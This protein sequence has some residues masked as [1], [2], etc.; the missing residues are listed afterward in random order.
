[1]DIFDFR[2]RLV[3][4]Y[5]NYVKS[6][7]RIQNERINAKVQDSFDRG[8]LWPDPLLQL[9]PFFA[10]GGQIDELI[11]QGQLAAEC[12]DIFRIKKDSKNPRGQALRLHKHQ[13]EAVEIA[14]QGHHYVLTTGTGS[15]KS[16]A[17]IVPIVNHILRQ[18]SGKGIQAIVVYPMN[19]L[20][21]SQQ[22][23]LEK[24][25]GTTDPAVTFNRYTGQDK[26]EA[27]RQILENPP[28]ILLTNYVMLEL[29]LTRPRENALIESAKGLQF[30]V[31]DELHTY[32]GRQGADVAMLVRRVRDRLSANN[33]Q[34]V[35]TSATMSTEGTYLDRQTAVAAVASQIFG[36]TVQP[37]HVIGE[38]LRRIT[39]EQTI[40]SADF[41]ERLTERVI[42][43]TAVPQD[44]ENFVQDPL[45]I[46]IES[47]FGIAKESGSDRYVRQKPISL[48]GNEGAAKK[49][50]E[51][52]KVDIPQCYQTL[53]IALLRGYSCA[54]PET[55]YAPFGFRLHQFISKGGAV[56]ASLEDTEER[57]ITLQAQQYVPG[58]R[59][60]ILLPLVFCRE[61]GQEYYCVRRTHTTEDIWELTARELSDSQSES[62]DEAGFI[63]A[64]ADN[65][66]SDDW[67]QLEE[68]LPDDWLEEHETKRRGRHTRVK[69]A[70]RKHLPEP[71]QFKA[72]GEL[73]SKQGPLQGRFLPA[74]FR[75]CLSCGVS[76]GSR[77][78]SDFA[79][80]STLGTEGR[81]TATTILGL[82]SILSLRESS[83]EENAKKLLSFTDNRQDAALQA[84]HFNDF[85]E[86]GLLRAAV[87]A[88]IKNQ[89]EGVE[90]DELAQQVF[91]ALNLPLSLYASDPDVQYQALKQTK[92]ALRDVLG[93]RLYLDLRRGW[94]I[95]SPNLEQ[96]GLLEIAYQS[97]EEACADEKIWQ[98][99]HLALSSATAQ[100]RTKVARVLLDY[101]RR[102]LAIKVNYLD[103]DYQERM[104]QRSSQ[105][106]IDPWSLDDNERLVHSAVLFPRPS[107]K[108]DF[109]GNVFLSPRGGFGYYIMRHST[110]QEVG[111]R[112][113]LTDAD[114][115]IKDLL[116]GLRK[117]G[118]VE[119]VM[120]PKDAEDVPGYQLVADTMLWTVG[121]GQ[122]AFHDPI[123]VPQQSKTGGNTNDFFVDFYKSTAAK[124]KN[125]EAREH[126]AQVPSEERER[127]EDAFRTA[128]LPLLFC[129]PTMEL[130]VDIDNLNVVSL[131]NIPPTPANYAQRSG[132][133]GRSGQPALVFSYCSTGSSHD[134]YFFKRPD[135]M[136]T[137]AVTP[138]R[139]DL[140]NE[141]L[142]RS[143]IH[144]IWLA[145]SG[146]FLGKSV[147]ELLDVTQEPPSLALGQ[148]VL[149]SLR[150]PSVRSRAQT[151]AENVLATIESV[152]AETDWHRAQWLEDVINQL[153]QSFERAC[154]RW[155]ELYRAALRQFELQSKII[156][157]VSRIARDKDQA[158]RLRR[159]A[160]NQLQILTQTD[161]FSQSDF[162]S[163]R[164]FA[165]EGFLPGY[166]FPRLPLSAYI[167]GR[168]RK[169]GTDEYLSRP[170]FLAISEFGPR[171]VVYHEGSKYLIN[172]V[173]LPVE[174]E[175]NAL[176]MQEVKQCDRCGYLHPMADG[177]GK[178]KCDR[179][180]A[181]L[182]SPLR[183]LFRLHNVSTQRRDKINSDEEERLRLGYDIYTGLRFQEIDGQPT[184]QTASVEYEGEQIAQLTYAQNAVLWRI[185][186]GWTRRKNK[187]QLGFVLDVE[188]GYWAKNELVTD[189][190]DVSDPMSPRT[191]RVIPYVQDTRNSLLFEPTKPISQEA[192]ASLQS[193]LKQAIQVQ[194]QLE[195]NEL[196]A[197]P[198]P[199]Q[200]KRRQILFYESAEGGAGVLKRLLDP[201]AMSLV[202][203]A[204]LEICHYT[205]DGENLG[206]APGAQEDCEAACYDCLMNYR[207]Q[208][209]HALLDRKEIRPDLLKLL[210]AKV[211]SSPSPKPRSE[212]LEGLLKQ[213]D[214][215]LEQQW[216]EHLDAR[217]Y[218]LPSHARRLIEDC[219]T[220]PDFAYAD[221]MTVVYVDGPHH[222]YSDRQARDAQQM[223]CLE[224]F[225]YTVVRF[226]IADNW[227]DILQQYPTVF[228]VANESIKRPEPLPITEAETL[229]LEDFDAEWRPLVK[230]LSEVEG[231]TVEPGGDV[232]RPVVGAFVALVQKGD[233]ALRLIDANDLAAD[234]V[235]KASNSEGIN[236][237][238]LNA[239]AT[240]AIAQVLA[241]I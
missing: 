76:Y 177:V 174:G 31:L 64:H 139:L 132:R 161:Q 25:L 113:K 38:T 153:E 141:E 173:I 213:C 81:S 240:D 75:F 108:K 172:R 18:G 208:R 231:I 80:L 58:D 122:Q 71:I 157:D 21:N 180:N 65:P 159:E 209:D 121:D 183:Q 234:D 211:K 230:A 235:Q 125:L 6:F 4:D 83:L 232:G 191:S 212:H 199:S 164:Y 179:C 221:Y 101:M 140:G 96:C 66:W 32:R 127:R 216:L 110:F 1:M 116:E 69:P 200:D 219:G 47:T 15:G 138:P 205:S 56:Y 94:R 190:E 33:M 168:R 189:E 204:A 91:D 119:A 237:L 210:Q 10:P 123:R 102:E 44:Y 35:G 9:N 97:L 46:W 188:R 93:Y 54:D 57:H 154:D 239:L 225:G 149:A 86:V 60:R 50:H 156:K 215:K 51:L 53:K 67:E 229:D 37:E 11:A 238:V 74:P 201:Q 126:T 142:L 109:K 145:E 118:L 136:V 131:R 133:A 150:D 227:D 99:T 129:S 196:A 41:V 8:L 115:I 128:E 5:S 167:E 30:L 135:R 111:E 3:Q 152:L 171:A 70:R 223:E 103:S 55:G 48:G 89:P 194:Y 198:L 107:T 224:D 88:A 117:A 197:E 228:G 87:Y 82:S 20:A 59:D 114:I 186:I 233:R 40:E 195:D 7:I 61:C 22:N 105:R 85:I 52:T 158:K 184:Y 203:Q 14:N 26:E 218:R 95:T 34:C 206:H 130:G 134:Q 160:E 45:S 162:N 169:R 27:R 63:Y 13:T 12:A 19:A 104:I 43:P 146:L 90:H 112:L 148:S 222:L 106:L 84:G 182:P 185:N 151:R 77:Q 79:K 226:A 192:M 100:T 73:C 23:E 166:S 236:A 144:A 143:H 207:N 163:Y 36:V 155:R 17:Y 29:I 68:R 24:F 78:K 62:N 217:G 214:S 42:A 202:A 92:Q 178:D 241:R 120:A 181:E 2:D 39:P 98:N 170:R 176:A 72:N 165:S 28:D 193:A 124:T 147:N 220:K 137:G 175:E 16:L 49:L 187:D